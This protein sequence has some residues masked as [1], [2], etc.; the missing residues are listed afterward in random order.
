M[1]VA[2]GAATVVWAVQLIDRAAPPQASFAQLVAELS[3]PGGFFDTDNLIS[4]EKSYLH[5]I[6]QLEQS[7]VAGGVYIGAG[8]DQNFSYIAR[9]RPRVAFILDIRRDNLLLHLL[10]KALFAESRNRVEY[11]SLL[12]GRPVPADTGK[13]RDADIDRIVA[14]LDGTKPSATPVLDRRIHATIARFGVP[15]SAEEYATIDRYHAVFINAGLSLQFQTFGRATQSYNPTYRELV[16]ETDR[17]GRKLSFLASEQDFQFV[18]SLQV[19]DGIIPVVGDF[20][21]THALTAIGKWMTAHNERLSA[22]YVSNVE[23]YLFRDG[24][25]GR[26]IENLKRL[27]H[28]DHS[29][30]IRSIFGRLAER[31][32]EPGYYSVSTVQELNEL[33][34]NF[35]AGK[36]RSYRS[37]LGQ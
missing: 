26:Y 12:T 31:E 6:P 28:Q 13:W 17:K 34:T 7:S 20:A 25:F 18:R 36:Y 19:R 1:A 33:L 11:L 37:L 9:I 5:V 24:G 16:T 32:S 4:N 23:D 15:L 8:P 27:P 35:A 2:L 30:V 3:E 10:F 21:G 29:V 14:Y 22:F